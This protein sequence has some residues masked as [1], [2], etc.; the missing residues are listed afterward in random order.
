MLTDSLR[1]RLNQNLMMKRCQKKMMKCLKEMKECLIRGHNQKQMILNYFL[2]NLQIP[3]DLTLTVVV[4]LV[5]N[6]FLTKR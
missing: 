4:V 3:M 6:S 5:K 2:I 1:N